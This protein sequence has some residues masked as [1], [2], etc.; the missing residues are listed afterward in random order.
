VFF[1]SGSA[2]PLPAT[3]RLLEVLGYEL[4]LVSLP[5]VVEGHTDARPF[6]GRGEYS[7]WELS[8]DRA[9]AARRLLQAGGTLESQVAAVRGLAAREPRLPDPYAPQNR[10]VTVLLLVPEAAGGPT[11]SAP[12]AP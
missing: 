7:N 4:A 11:G 9:N 10:R 6:A 12:G 8:A 1:A 2:A 5:V 3:V